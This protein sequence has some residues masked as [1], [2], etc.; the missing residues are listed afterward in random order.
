MDM[1]FELKCLHKSYY[2]NHL[3]KYVH[4]EINN[5]IFDGHACSK[6]GLIKYWRE[7]NTLK[8]R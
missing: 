7:K 1:H 3:A 2:L 6:K 4:I 5:I 8:Q